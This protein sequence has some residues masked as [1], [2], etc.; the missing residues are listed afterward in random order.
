MA[1][2]LFELETDPTLRIHFVGTGAGEAR[3]LVEVSTDG[4]I[5]ESVRAR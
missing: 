5:D 3:K 1:T 4:S 2:D